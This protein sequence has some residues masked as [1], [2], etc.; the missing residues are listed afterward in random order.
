[1]GQTLSD[2]KLILSTDRRLWVTAVFCCTVF[3]VW[4]MTD[5]WREE[6]PPPPEKFIN[7]KVIPEKIEEMVR[8][9]NTQ[10]KQAKEER[11]YLRDTMTRVG[12]EIE[13]EKE[14]IDWHTNTL[15]TKLNDVSE[16]V[17]KLVNVVGDQSIGKAK[18]ETKLKRQK[19][20]QKG[21]R[22]LPDG[23]SP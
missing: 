13:V 2:V 1:L 19:Q 12:Q 11:E 7:V 20:K 15:I 6:E 4:L 23:D 9:F 10:I 22:P 14:Q 3:G 5:S 21:I 17:D 8:G 16:K 18:L